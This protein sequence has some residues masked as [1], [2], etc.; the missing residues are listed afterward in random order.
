[1]K[2]KGSLRVCLGAT[3]VVIAAMAETALQLTKAK[4]S[5]A[6]LQIE[7]TGYSP[8]DS[9]LTVTRAKLEVEMLQADLDYRQALERLKTLMGER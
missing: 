5:A 7:R 2:F 3:A 9:Q 6:M 1:M 4:V 8:N